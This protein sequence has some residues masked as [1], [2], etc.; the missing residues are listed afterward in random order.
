MAATC[1]EVA[2]AIVA[3]AHDRRAIGEIAAARE[4]ARTV[5]AEAEASLRASG[6]PPEAASRA[7]AEAQLATARAYA[8]RIESREQSAVWDSV[9][10]TWER[11]GDPYQ[12]ARARW[13]QAEAALAASDDARTGRASGRAP[14]LEAVRI[15]RELGAVP[16]LRELETLARRALITL[17]SDLAASALRPGEVADASAGVGAGFWPETVLVGAVAAGPAAASP[18]A[19]AAGGRIAEAFVG[20]REPHASTAFGISN[21]EREVLGLIV[22]GRTNREI[23]ERL[24]ISQKTVG[25]HVG[26]ILAKLGVSGRVEAAM[27]AVR[28]DLIPP[29]GH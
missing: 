11:V 17:P 12:V 20:P 23:G 25:V 2:A 26:N 5:L 8:A 19:T 28:L 3:D 4:R 14:L 21:R 16:L 29:R 24:F 7:E 15:A 22:Q 18:D 27:V 10:R 9:A 1:L 6:V 13:R